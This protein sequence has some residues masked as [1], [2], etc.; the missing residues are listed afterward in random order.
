MPSSRAAPEGGKIVY[1]IDGAHLDEMLVVEHED[2]LTTHP[3]GFTRDGGTLY[4]ISSIGRDKAALFA[5]DLGERRGAACLPS[6]PRPTSA[7]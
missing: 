1:R 7:A 4:S 6:I 5:T 3:I 2:D